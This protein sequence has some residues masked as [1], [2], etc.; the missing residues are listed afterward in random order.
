MK[1]GEADAL[2]KTMNL[3]WRF[4]KYKGRKMEDLPSSYL[5]WAAENFSNDT[6]AAACSLIWNY[7]KE[8]DTHKED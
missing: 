3:E 7:R 8:T 2:E 6:W 5:K 1:E 4:G